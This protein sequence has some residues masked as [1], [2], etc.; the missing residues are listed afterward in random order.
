MTAVACTALV[1]A[2]AGVADAAGGKP[3][4]NEAPGITLE[5][6]DPHLGGTVTFAVT[7]PRE[8]KYPRVAVR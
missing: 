6:T 4:V 1:F 7:D 2:L 3:R 5:Q 8:V